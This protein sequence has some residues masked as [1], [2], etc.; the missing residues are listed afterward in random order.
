MPLFRRTRTAVVADGL[1][2]ARVEGESLVAVARRSSYLHV[3]EQI[4]EQNW[5]TA[6]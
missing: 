2:A 3:S 4:N 6:K 1:A 5:F